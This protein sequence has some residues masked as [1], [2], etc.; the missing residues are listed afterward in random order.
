[1][2]AAAYDVPSR[3]RR[4]A[5]LAFGLIYLVLPAR[6]IVTGGV[7][8]A[9]VPWAWA[10]LLAFAIS[11]VATALSPR[12]FAERVPWTYPLLWL[13]TLLGVVPPLL[14]GGAWLGLPVFTVVLHAMILPPRPAAVS[15]GGMLVVV[16]G[17]GLLVGADPAAIAIYGLQAVTLGLL[18]MGVRRSRLLTQQLRAAEGEMARL[19]ATEE[20]LRI[21]RD[22]HDLLGHSMS[23]IV[24]KA[25]LA[26]RLAERSPQAQREI[27]D[28][29]AVARKALLEVRQAVTGYRRLSLPEELDSATAVLRAAGVEVRT[30][31]S[32]LPL[33]APLDGLLAWAVREGTTNVVRHAAARRCDLDVT[34]DGE[35]AMLVIV[36]DGR[37]AEPYEP[38]SGLKGLGERVRAAGGELA[39]GPEPAGGFG[40]RARVP[41]P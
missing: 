25:E 3:G 6:E 8:G 33:P 21:A 26:G 17:G 41:A 38:G 13:T 30:R 40:V 4:L 11:Y 20:R 23:L 14:F 28:I 2:S 19:A 32:G 35:Q 7:P 10:M 39:A 16:A 24:L 31:R 34:Y 1:M 29:E 12:T 5:G 27:R 22:L 15:L 37:G 9:G 36:D 18:F